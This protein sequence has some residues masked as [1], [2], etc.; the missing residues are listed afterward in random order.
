[1]YR[2]FSRLYLPIVHLD[3]VYCCYKILVEGVTSASGT[4][5][6][7]LADARNRFPNLLAFAYPSLPL[8]LRAS[9]PLCVSFYVSF[10]A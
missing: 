6:T 5:I 8:S 3:Y 2:Y 10:F 9:V 1:M 7:I 4:L